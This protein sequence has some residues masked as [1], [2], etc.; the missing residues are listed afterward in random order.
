MKATVYIPEDKAELYE[1]AKA[2]LGGTISATFL[3]CLE[4]E[5]EMKR[6]ATGRIVV[7]LYDRKVDRVVKKAFV[8]RWII[9]EGEENQFDVTTSGFQCRGMYSV[10]ITKERRIVV[11]SGKKN[12]TPDTFEVYDDLDDFAAA[13]AMDGDPKYPQGLI[14]AVKVA[15]GFDHI[16]ELDI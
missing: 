14:A 13:E 15:L 16:E 5:L 6:A 9:F 12:D 1:K 3:R 7:T 2:E 11:V 4:Q 10:A 8:G